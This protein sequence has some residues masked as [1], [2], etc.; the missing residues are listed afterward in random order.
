[1][2]SHLSRLDDLA[3]GLAIGPDDGGRLRLGPGWPKRWTARVVTAAGEATVPVAELAGRP[4][5]CGMVP[6]RR[7][8]W[9]RRQRHR[10]GLQ[11]LVGTG[12]HHGFESLAEQQLLLVVDF[13]GVVEVV[14]QPLELRMTTVEGWA[15]HVPDFLVVAR[16][17]T[18]LIDVR[19]AGRVG[20]EDRLR[21]AASAEVALVAG[22]R[23][24]VVT[25]WQP[26]V[27]DVVDALSAQRRPLADPL[28]VQPQ[29]LAAAGVGPVAFAAL[30][31]A[32]SWPGVAR[33]HTLHLLWH[34]QLALDLAAGLGE[35][36]RVWA[37]T[38]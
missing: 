3:V 25:G 9:A 28:G 8:S 19:P 18:W 26:N 27:F 12:R 29:L 5:A 24:L 13:L 6:L 37:V 31:A 17:G 21:F 4:V 20:D 14:S 35:H 11:Y 2:P 7:F 1:M 23:Y 10:P 33:A 15:R 36:T 38:P 32:A 16:D 34:R 30:V 22:W